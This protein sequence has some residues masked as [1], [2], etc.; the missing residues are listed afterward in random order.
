MTGL[1]RPEDLKQISSDAEMAKMDEERAV[2]EKERAAR[3]GAAR[4][5]H[6]AR[7]PA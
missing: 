1:L 4:S 6:V 5:L 3:A 7:C 2:Q